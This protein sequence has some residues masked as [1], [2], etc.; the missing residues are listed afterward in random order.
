MSI[1]KLNVEF[2]KDTIF[3]GNCYLGSVK[4]TCSDWAESAETM[5][6]GKIVLFGERSTILCLPFLR[7]IVILTSTLYAS[8]K[9]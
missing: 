8:M 7:Q 2:Q 9:S 4:L 5:R 3:C 1:L 6:N